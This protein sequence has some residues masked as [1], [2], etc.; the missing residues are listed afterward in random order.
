MKNVFLLLFL[1]LFIA[2]LCAKIFSVYR[3]LV[4]ILIIK[5]WKYMIL[6][7]LTITCLASELDSLRKFQV[8]NEKS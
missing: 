3:A 8:V 4:I 1:D 2:I 5:D 6:T 7:I